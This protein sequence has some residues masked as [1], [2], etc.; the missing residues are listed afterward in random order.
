M[1]K[2]I[3][4][5]AAVISTCLGAAAQPAPQ[6]ARGAGAVVSASSQVPQGAPIGPT[7][8]A[9]ILSAPS[10]NVITASPEA[11]P[12]PPADGRATPLPMTRE[13][14]EARSRMMNP[15]E[16]SRVAAYVL[17]RR[18]GR[19]ERG[20][21]VGMR[22]VRDPGPRFAFQFKRN[23]AAT[24]ARYTRDPRFT[25]REGGLT[26]AE[27]QPIMDTWWKR[28]EPYRLV[29]GGS[30]YEFEGV[31][32]LG[33]NIDEAAFREIAARERWVLPDRLELRFAPPRNP[34]SVDPALTR[35]VRVFARQARLP[36]IYLLMRLGGRVI[37]RDG[38]FRLTE[39]GEAGEPLVVFARDAELG[40]DP[41]GYMVLGGAG[42]GRASPRIGERMT[43]AGPQD[44]SE[45]DP[46]VKLL[47]RICGAG[48]IVAVGGAEGAF[49]IQ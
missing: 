9:T 44:Y 22:I 34:R 8:Y 6:Q 18:I 10:T 32:R 23:A 46:N 17:D 21:Y 11:P 37:L 1:K 33:M 27:L 14:R 49:S 24:L 36:A 15:D 28:F 42:S 31:V 40:L 47:R 19:A 16:A 45:A 7:G 38:C 12:P 20:N 35:Y 39:H 26:T 5:G 4:I 25:S 29:G 3:A 48:P 2:S 13:A 30:V 41:Q 43:W